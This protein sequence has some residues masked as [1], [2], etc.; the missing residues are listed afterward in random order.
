MASEDLDKFIDPGQD[1]A[2][3]SQGFFVTE[4]GGTA[5]R[6]IFVYKKALCIAMMGNMIISIV[7][8]RSLIIFQMAM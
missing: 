2:L 8:Y 5:F 3:H 4:Q 7:V 6:K 1:T